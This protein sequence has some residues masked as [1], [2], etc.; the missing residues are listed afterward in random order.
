MSATS[1]ATA[2]FM[3]TWAHGLDVYEALGIEP[4]P[5]DRIRHV[6]TSACAPATSRSPSTSS[7]GPTTT[8]R[9]E[10]TSPSGDTWA[11]GP[12]DAAQR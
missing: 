6:A 9:V 1:M 3:E 12:E 2:R 5:T 10:L 7:T 4:E 11:W 8:F